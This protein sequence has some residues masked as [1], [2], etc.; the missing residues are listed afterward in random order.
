MTREH[1]R[2]QLCQKEFSRGNSSHIHHIISKN[3]GGTDR[4]KNLSLLHK[5]CHKRLHKQKLFHLL[6]VNRNYKAA[7]FMNIVSIRFRSALPGCN[8]TYGNETFVKRNFLGLEKSHYNDAFIIAGG[9][10]QKKIY[11]IYLNQKHRNNRKLQIDRKGF[12]PSIRRKRYSIQPCDIISV[13]SKKYLVKSC[14][15]YGTAV[16]C[17]DGVDNFDFGIKKIGNIFHSKSIYVA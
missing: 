2:C 9:N 8:I 5:K 10:R 13:N 14:F 4:E 15:N 17:T 12:R 6:N 1:G 3:N 7:T 11:P 16:R